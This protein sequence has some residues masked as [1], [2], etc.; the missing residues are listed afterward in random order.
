MT[1]LQISIPL[2]TYLTHPSIHSVVYLYIYLSFYYLSIYPYLSL[3]NHVA[4]CL[5]YSWFNI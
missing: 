5:E 1:V 3:L 2:P 4:L